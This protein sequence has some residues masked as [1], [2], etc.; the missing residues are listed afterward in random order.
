MSGPRPS[1]G[2][3]KILRLTPQDDIA[4]RTTKILR[5]TP[6][7]DIPLTLPVGQRQG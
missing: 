4:L 1:A 3:T 5:L 6:Q 7:D 2:T